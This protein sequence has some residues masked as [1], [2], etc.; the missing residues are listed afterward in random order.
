M[1]I[2]IASVVSAVI[3]FFAG[4]V[5]WALLMQ[6]AKPAGV[7]EDAALV[8]HMAQSL[9]STGL[10]IYPTYM[11]DTSNEAGPMALVYF[12]SVKPAMGP[13]MGKGFA[14][15]LASSVIVCLI[16]YNFASDS[17]AKRF[18]CVVWLGVFVAVWADL[19]NM[20]WWNHP[21][22]WAAFHCGYEI[23]SWTIAGLAIAAIV[24][25]MRPKS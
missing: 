5:W 11:K 22:F 8:E 18:T 1:R 20:I 16:V 4:F 3:L 13:T 23:V 12:N 25:P 2:A 24:K 7:I 9:G 6:A 15:M 14:H 10:Y 19:G 21:P 17:F